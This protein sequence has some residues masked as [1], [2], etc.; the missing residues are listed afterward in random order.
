MK[1]LQKVE[2]IDAYVRWRDGAK[3]RAWTGKRLD[4]ERVLMTHK[5]GSCGVYNHKKKD[6]EDFKQRIGT[7]DLEPTW[8]QIIN[9]TTA[10]N[11][12]VM[13][14][15]LL[16]LAK[17]GDLVRQAQKNNEVLTL[18]PNGKISKVKL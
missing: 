16:R 11:L 9:A 8:E 7:I 12:D 13:R 14:D 17:V 18:F 10:S 2:I 1:K 3:L 5:T 15:E 4:K 6:V